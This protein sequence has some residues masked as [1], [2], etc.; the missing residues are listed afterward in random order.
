MKA[1]IKN[2]LLEAGR[3]RGSCSLWHYWQAVLCRRALCVTGTEAA[4]AAHFSQ[5]GPSD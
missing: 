4:T 1:N 5:A 3:P 2:R